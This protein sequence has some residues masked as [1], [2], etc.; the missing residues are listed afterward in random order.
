MKVLLM[1][2]HPQKH[3]TDKL[4]WM[5]TQHSYLNAWLDWLVISS[6]SHEYH[7]YVTYLRPLLFH[8][9]TLAN[10]S[11]MR[12]RS[13]IFLQSRFLS[14]LNGQELTTWLDLL[15]FLIHLRVQRQHRL[16]QS[17]KVLRTSYFNRKTQKA[18]SVWC[19]S[20]FFCKKNQSSQD[21]ILQYLSYCIAF[22]DCCRY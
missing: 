14:R 20:F 17:E 16:K 21:S 10:C 12:S 5:R 8:R 22:D 11:R 18:L 4:I 7:P 19:Q 2:L 9:N 15:N 6:Q 1:G 13:K 3:S